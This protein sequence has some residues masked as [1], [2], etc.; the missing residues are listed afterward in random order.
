MRGR[1]GIT[2]VVA[3]LVVAIVP[4]AAGA[5]PTDGGD[6]PARQGYNVGPDQ[7]AV[8]CGLH[9]CIHWVTEPTDPDAP[10]QVDDDGD[11]VPDYV[12]AASD[13]FEKAWEREVDDLGF[14]AP[15]RDGGATNPGPNAKLDV[16]L[17][18]LDARGISG[19]C[20]SDDPRDPN[21]N[22]DSTYEYWDAAVYC[23]V[24][25]D[26]AGA[27]A[28]S[29]ELRL[30]AAHELFHAVQCAYD[31]Y[32]DAWLAEGTAA[33]IE[34][35]V[36]PRL[37]QGDRYVFDSQVADPTNPLDSGGSLAYG[38]WFFWDF[39]ADRLG[40]PTTV[41]RQLWEMAADAP[42]GPRR[43]SLQAATRLA[44][45]H[46]T[47]LRSELA[48]FGR[49]AFADRLSARGVEREKIGRRETFTTR[50]RLDH[51]TFRT[52]VLRPSRGVR[53]TDLLAVRLNLPPRKTGPVATV[54]T[55]RRNGDRSVSRVEL[56]RRGNGRIR[57]DFGR[58][59]RIVVTLTNASTRMDCNWETQLACGGYARDDG[60]RYRLV[61]EVRR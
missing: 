39:F 26:F 15:L 11:G 17:V 14:R 2:L 32:E 10:P 36:Y 56:N 51:L 29:I 46:D 28:P 42:G 53:R 9:V 18:D 55:V 1:R 60:L 23:V 35:Q 38:A 21:V 12:I 57:V 24:D 50:P 22:A 49:R 4:T 25:N 52:I 59:R 48:A 40:R 16:Y 44:R 37:A 47:T 6:D 34:A 33:W 30:T 27:P 5:R 19:V 41:I 45:R 43:Y 58:A 20:R 3:A 54:T 8:G 31:C 7:V 13:A 61:A